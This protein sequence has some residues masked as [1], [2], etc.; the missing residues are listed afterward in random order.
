[1]KNLLITISL[2]LL[3]LGIQAQDI[4]ASVNQNISGKAAAGSWIDYSVDP[5]ADKISFSFETKRTKKAAKFEHYT[6]DLGLNYKGMEEEEIELQKAKSKFRFFAS[7]PDRPLL[8]VKKNW[9]TGQMVM[10]SGYISYGYAGRALITNFVT[11]NKVKPKGI[12]GN[13]LLLVHAR[14]ESPF[15]YHTM[16][17]SFF[18]QQTAMSRTGTTGGY[19]KLAYSEGDVCAIVYEKK[20]PSFQNYAL[21]VIDADTYERKLRAPIT[22]DK[23]YRALY[24][25]DMPNGDMAL[26]FAPVL[27]VD[28]PKSKK[29]NEYNVSD[30]PIY[31]YVRVNMKGKIVDEVNFE[32]AKNKIGQPYTFAI[33]PDADLASTSAYIVGYGNADML[34]GGGLQEVTATWAATNGSVLPRA[35]NYAAGKVGKLFF[36][37]VEQGKLAYFNKMTPD[38]FFANTVADDVKVP[39]GKDVG[40]FILSALSFHEARTINGKDYLIGTTFKGGNVFVPQFGNAGKLEKVY[41]TKPV[42]DCAFQSAGLLGMKDGS[43]RLLT[44]YQDHSDS[45]EGTRQKDFERTLKVIAL[46]PNSGT[47]GNTIDVLPKKHYIDPVDPIRFISD[48]EFLVLG[49]SSRKDVTLVKVK[50]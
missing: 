14:T 20:A 24:V 25:R 29:A 35:T 17:R 4:V 5:E 19:G 3:S 37:K 6:F 8:R 46:D 9:A 36:G 45:P 40:K 33:I 27:N 28:L 13:K 21:M 41:L 12:D 26:I 23:A 39:A 44:T 16:G 43:L 49:H 7:T 11:Q 10:E 1:M 15:A 50:L 47:I 18:G 2:A 32:L 34:G 48:D 42:K 22:F 38:Q 30:K 31:K